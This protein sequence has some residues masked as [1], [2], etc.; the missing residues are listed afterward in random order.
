ME[1]TAILEDIMEQKYISWFETLR[2]GVRVPGGFATT[3]AAYRDFMA[4]DGLDKR[5]QAS[6]DKL[7]V[8]DVTAL[9]QVGNQIR[10][11]IVNTP[12]PLR[13][14]KEIREAHAAMLAQAGD[15]KS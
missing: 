11:W 15:R 2:M 1:T 13:L 7:D 4:Q 6:L 3:A 5:I 12:L 10:Q 9:A 14:E 8:A